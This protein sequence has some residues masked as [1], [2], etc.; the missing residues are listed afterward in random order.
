MRVPGLPIIRDCARSCN[1]SEHTRTHLSAKDVTEKIF[2]ERLYLV[3]GMRT[4]APTVSVHPQLRPFKLQ[5]FL[6]FST[7]F[8]PEWPL[9][10]FNHHDSPSNLAQSRVLGLPIRDC[11]RGCNNCSQSRPIMSAID[12]TAKTFFE[13]LYLVLRLRKIAP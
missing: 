13:R 9:I 12:V 4:F 11:A 8:F 10:F 7:N 2:F 6:D 3:S 5:L 1:N